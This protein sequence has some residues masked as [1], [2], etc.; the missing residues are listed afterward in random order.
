[1]VLVSKSLTVLVSYV[2]VSKEYWKHREGEGS[3][4]RYTI[5]IGGIRLYGP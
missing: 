2:D 5:G 4:P 3:V 1:M